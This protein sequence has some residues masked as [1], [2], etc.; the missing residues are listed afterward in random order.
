MIEFEKISKEAYEAQLDIWKD[1]CK[2]IGKIADYDE[3]KLPARST[4]GSAGYDFF[5]PVN[6]DVSMSQRECLRAGYSPYIVEET[7]EI[8]VP[9]FIKCKMD[10]N[11][12][13][14][15]YPRSGLANKYS[16]RFKNTIPVID[17]DYYN[18]DG[19]GVTKEGH[20][21]LS[22]KINL[23]NEI[24]NTPLI[25]IK[26]FPHFSLE[27]GDKMI[28]GIFHNYLT[29]SNEDKSKLKTRKGGFGS[30]DTKL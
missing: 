7:A 13:L 4:T 6:I 11:V 8:V 17:S 14:A 1:K 24:K 9:T 15:L 10:E 29:V 19:D 2:Y 30:S 23:S 3:I 5:S 16:F 25:N 28:Q 20:I 26:A 22:V 18:S 21:I 27:I 12:Y